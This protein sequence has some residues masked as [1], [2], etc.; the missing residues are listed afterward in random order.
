MPLYFRNP[1]S[2][3][4]FLVEGAVIDEGYQLENEAIDGISF[5]A[6]IG[7]IRQW[8]RIRLTDDEGPVRFLG[9]V[10]STTYSAAGGPTH[11]EC[12]SAEGLLHH[13]YAPPIA[14]SGGIGLTLS[15]IFSSDAPPQ[16]AGASQYLMP[17]LWLAI[18]KIPDGLAS[19]DDDGIATL[20]GWDGATSGRD[21]YYNG[22]LCS[23]VALGSIAGGNYRCARD[24]G[25]LYVRGLGPGDSYGVICADGFAENWIRLGSIDT[26]SSLDRVYVVG[27]LRIWD[28][29][30]D[31]VEET[32]QY[33]V[34]RAEE[35]YIYLDIS[36]SPRS[37]GT[38][39]EPLA[40]LRAGEDFN[41]V[42][43]DRPQKLPAQVVLGLGADYDLVWGQRYGAG[44]PGDP[45]QA[46]IEETLSMTNARKSPGGNLDGAASDLWDILRAHAPV[47]VELVKPRSI[48]PG[49]W[50]SIDLGRGD[51]FAAQA[52]RVDAITGK[53]DQISFGAPDLSLQTSLWEKAETSAIERYRLIYES[54][55]G[56]AI[57]YGYLGATE[58]LE[59]HF[60]TIDYGGGYVPILLSV[61]AVDDSTVEGL[62]A[63]VHFEIDLNGNII[64]IPWAPW[65]PTPITDFDI[66]RWCNTDGTQNDFEI[67]VI[68]PAGWIPDD[69]LFT[70]RIL[71]LGAD[72]PADPVELRINN[73]TL[74][75]KSTSTYYGRTTEGTTDYVYALLDTMEMPISE[76]FSVKVWYRMMAY[77]QIDLDWNVGTK[78]YVAS[79]I[80]VGG[81]KYYG[82]YITAKYWATWLSTS[83]ATNPKTGRAWAI[84]DLNAISAGGS[85][86]MDPY[87][88]G[89]FWKNHGMSR[90]YD[91]YVEVIPT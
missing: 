80:S 38:E 70:A 54:L 82:S 74:N 23:E 85:C 46:W 49:D 55:T 45:G 40:T 30:R 4:E 36:A 22:H 19:W 66:G 68:D 58:S 63:G 24:G 59:N 31:L 15:D 79:I 83:Y 67:S 53:P 25:D 61:E 47:K 26:D 57:R 81:T 76:S 10:I 89:R 84:D 1:G 60:D 77:V 18:S 51:A 2:D 7:H 48:R 5:D 78:G 50:Y 21:I 20:E 29:I 72:N 71:G 33:V 17:L 43:L 32:G 42:S 90:L 41:I 39:A 9:A 6:P 35:D 75:D 34:F 91:V 12:L 73:A 8:A 52:R 3:T 86:K 64:R 44:S 56:E 13:R 88:P 14:Y 87:A 62:Q 27:W 16:G 65:S 37:R 28:L 11:Y 69:Y